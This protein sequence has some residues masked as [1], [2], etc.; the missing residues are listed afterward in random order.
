MAVGRTTGPGSEPGL[1]GKAWEGPEALQLVTAA[2]ASFSSTRHAAMGQG[3]AGWAEWRPLLRPDSPGGGRGCGL[4][5]PRSMG[6]VLGLEPHA[7]H[8]E[9]QH[10]DG[11]YKM[12]ACNSV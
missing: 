12:G 9:C 3:G 7:T 5:T 10:R 1:L 8:T 2:R 4:A 6:T 11:W